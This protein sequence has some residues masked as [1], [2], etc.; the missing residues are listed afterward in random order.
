MADQLANY[1]ELEHKNSTG[2]SQ[3]E[4][5][6]VQ[7]TQNP[8]TYALNLT[9][10]F[11]VLGVSS[12]DA[13]DESFRIRFHLITFR[14]MSLQEKELL[15]QHG[16]H[17]FEKIINLT[18]EP[19][20]A[21]DIITLEPITL[22]NNKEF[23]IDTGDKNNPKINEI[24]RGDVVFYEAFEVGNFPFDLEHLG[25]EFDFRYDTIDIN[26]GLYP[27][28]CNDIW[29][30]FYD[31]VNING[32]K[33][34]GI[35]TGCDNSGVDQWL[36]DTKKRLLSAN[37]E[38]DKD[39]DKDKDQDNNNINGDETDDINNIGGKTG[40]KLMFRLKFQR[41]WRYFFYRVIVVLSIIS[42]LTIACFLFGDINES[43]ADRFGYVSTML[44]TAVAYMLVVVGFIPQIDYLTLLDKYVYFTFIFILLIG[45][46][47]GILSMVISNNDTSDDYDEILM[48][49][50][51]LLW[52]MVHFAFFIVANKAY[53]QE[54]SKIFKVKEEVSGNDVNGPEIWANEN[55][56][57]Y[58]DKSCFKKEI[59]VEYWA[60]SKT[61]MYCK[62]FIQ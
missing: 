26:N 17:N 28:K 19:L 32:W 60:K 40:T 22:N 27:L 49:I 20:I 51:C 50:N 13:V 10:W 42:F 62:N 2:Q 30:W 25:F 16:S 34:I 21:K 58:D 6:T 33:F 52:V 14:E 46:E 3:P 43:I 31:P 9:V 23:T 11:G 61:T 39:T 8:D 4:N 12:I 53:Q 5:H 1:M 35:E 45:I 24:W 55:E 59:D 15:K 36:K 54:C 37:E 18:V 48:G 56:W 29:M 41:K 38:K 57:N 47:N 7:F 44:L